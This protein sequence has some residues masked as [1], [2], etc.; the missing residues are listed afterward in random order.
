MRSSRQWTHSPHC[1]E[2]SVTTWSPTATDVDARADRL[3]DAGALVAE[4]R[5]RVPGGID[6]R[7]RVQVG[8]ADAAGDEAHQHLARLRLGQLELLDL[9]R[10][11][12]LLEDRGANLH[13][14]SSAPQVISPRRRYL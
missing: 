10:C 12:E 6:T 11:S 2:N 13:D 9:E 5:R 3:D 14:I 4:H 7:R 8:V 1:G